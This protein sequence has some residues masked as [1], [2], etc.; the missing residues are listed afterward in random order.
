MPEIGRFAD[1]LGI[2]IGNRSVRSVAHKCG[3]SEAVLRKYLSGAS[4]PNVDR[5]CALAEC[6]NVSVEWLAT[7]EGPM[8]REGI[9]QA[10][11]VQEGYA[12]IPLYDVR[13]AAGGGAIVEREDIVGLVLF[14][15]VWIE[16]ELHLQPA[17]LYLLY[18]EG[19]SMEPTLRPGDLALIDHSARHV[20]RDGIYVIRMGDALLVK[21]IQRLPGDALKVTSDN[22]AYE[23]FTLDLSAQVAG[24]L[25]DSMEIVGRVVWSG[26]KM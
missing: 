13:A 2:A 21:R 12:K 17:N 1:R 10:G 15:R 22:T 25:L 9:S 8:R 4:T 7:G 5:L 20:N 23:P 24:K 3:V 6:L 26:R 16:R 11:V 18:I 19:D 14:S